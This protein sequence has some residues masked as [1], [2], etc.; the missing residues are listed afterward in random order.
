M[1]KVLVID[2]NLEICTLLKS[3]LKRKD[4]EVETASSGHEGLKKLKSFKPHIILC[5]FRLPD[6]DGLEMI[7]EIKSFDSTVQ[8][9][10]ITG[11][12]DV[13]LAVKAI[14]V[15]AFEYV[16]KPIFPEEILLTIKDAERKAKRVDSEEGE[17]KSQKKSTQK[18]P[19]NKLSPKVIKGRSERSKQLQ[20][21]IELVAPTNMTVMI[22]G[23]SGTGKEVTASQIHKLGSRSNKQFVAVDCGALPANI[24]GSELFGH[25]KG[26]F[27]GAL[28]DKRGY[29][30]QADG[31]TLF[32][33]EI[34]NLSYENQIKLLRVL[35][36]RKIR[37]LG[38]EK[39]IDVDVRVIVATNDELKTKVNDGKFREDLYY[40]LNEFKLELPA[41]RERN[42]DIEDFIKHFIALSNS[43]LE[44]DVEGVDDKVLDKFKA[45]HWPGNIRELR[46]VI[47]RAVLL[48]QENVI[49]ELHIPMEILNP[50]IVLADDEE[51]GE[52]ITDLKSVVERAEKKA[53]VKVLKQTSFN[54]T[55]ASKIL[56]VD[57][58]T[59]YNKM[60][61]YGL[62]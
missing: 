52:E 53:I 27:T 37:R 55:R 35:Q 60:K 21:L 23:E 28:K 34:G 10:I 62:D 46:N 57:R 54:R 22:L 44:K 58:K 48:T 5:D 12:G 13:R 25:I 50:T 51:D 8:V 30:E 1:S 3:F 49:K 38:G 15:G 43:D 29:F 2:D 39:D 36:E 11:Y 6:R 18:A 33:D 61:S 47:K 31:G 45:Y 32:L 24:A 17:S 16:T 59:L 41:L 9:I 14:K 40:R 4:F 42:R 56:D 19:R 7:K 26:A 20:S